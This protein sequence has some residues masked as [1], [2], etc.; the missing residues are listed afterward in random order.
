[1]THSTTITPK[2]ASEKGALDGFQVTCTCGHVAG[3]S[4]DVLAK[5]HAA[6]H[7]RWHERKA[8]A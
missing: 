5:Q 6:A 2:P 8:G 4:L 7:L 1:M 3:S